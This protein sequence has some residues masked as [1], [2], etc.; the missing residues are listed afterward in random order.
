MSQVIRAP[1]TAR[2]E[3][4]RPADELA[5]RKGDP[6]AENV[7][8]ARRIEEMR[9]IAARLR[10][11]NAQL[12]RS[13]GDERDR[14]RRAEA[15]ARAR[16][17][18]LGV[19]AHEL[20]SPLSL[21]GV[22]A[23][24]L[25]EF[26]SRGPHRD[27]MLGNVMRAVDQMDR[28]INDLLDVVRIEAGRL[29]IDPAPTTARTLLGYAEERFRPPG[30]EPRV[31][32]EVDSLLQDV[33]LNADAGRLLQ[34]FGNL[35][36]NALKF[37]APSGRVVLRARPAADRVV[38]EVED[39]GPGITPDQL[40]RL[41]DRFWQGRPADRRG[42][43]LGLAIARG[44]VDAHGG[45]VWAESRVGEG[46]TFAFAIPAHPSATLPAA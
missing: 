12:E 31:H 17:E 39:T 35:I 1:R 21:I 24:V 15:A 37:S 20:R 14:R 40:E 6:V 38:F 32:V 10:E 26:D 22:T 23:E 42:V 9:V 36:G 28:L 41:F 7:E 45:R 25:L 44:I 43:G 27:R 5:D 16:E 18:I 33:P 8:L 11:A 29:S 19:V 2:P 4:K 3:A 13:A 46:S 30:G 34:V